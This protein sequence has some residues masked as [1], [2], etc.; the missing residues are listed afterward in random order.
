MKLRFVLFFLATCLLG[1]ERAYDAKANPASDLKRAVEQAR[2]E[3]KNILLEVGGEWCSWCHRLDQL[4]ASNAGLLEEREKNFVFLKV[5]FS[6]ENENKEFLAQ[7]PKIEGY[8]HLIVLDSGGKMLR[9]Q[10]TDVLEEG[11]GYNLQRV[12]AFLR[13]WAPKR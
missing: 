11:K 6:P 9:S 5:N 13:E 10:E 3:K 7:Y 12:S 1:A 8:P 4:F 2:K